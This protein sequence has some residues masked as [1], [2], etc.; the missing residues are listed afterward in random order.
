MIF[1]PS[2]QILEVGTKFWKYVKGLIF[3]PF[4]PCSDILWW[5]NFGS[6]KSGHQGSGPIFTDLERHFLL[7]D[8]WMSR[9]M[10]PL[11]RHQVFFISSIKVEPVL[12][13]TLYS[14]TSGRA[15]NM[16]ANHG[17]RDLRHYVLINVLVLKIILSSSSSSSSSSPPS[18]LRWD[19]DEK[20]SLKWDFWC[21]LNL[22]CSPTTQLNP[23]WW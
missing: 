1:L 21:W 15:S 5:P 11:K 23:T 22:N 12:A 14:S 3:L 8:R 9:H 13:K 17:H 4:I 7:S 18:S 19:K 2:D 10:R 6:K 20:V 16:Y